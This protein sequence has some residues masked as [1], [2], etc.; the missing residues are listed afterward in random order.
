MANKSVNK[1]FKI[2]VVILLEQKEIVWSSKISLYIFITK[3]SNL[4]CIISEFKI[5]HSNLY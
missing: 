5:Q 2:P 4:V 1:N 3:I